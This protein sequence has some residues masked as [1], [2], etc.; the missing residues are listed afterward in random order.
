MDKPFIIGVTG[1]SGSGK[2]SFVR[3]LKSDFDSSKVAFLSQDDYYHPREQQVM[4]ENG[5]RN[6]DLLDSIDHKL[7]AEDI[8]TIINGHSLTKTKYVFNNPYAEPEQFT[9]QPA[10][11]ILIEGL[12]VFH[13]EEIR[14]LMDL[15][16]FIHA[17]EQKVFF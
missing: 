6:F 8:S 12:F 10:P 5:Y 14:N 17:D 15:R 9:V 13:F 16:V 7:F 4:D 1:G 3:K 2:T 11:L